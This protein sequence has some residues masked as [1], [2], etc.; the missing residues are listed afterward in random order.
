M[1]NILQPQSF[2][3]SWFSVPSNP[4]NPSNGP[5]GRPR[6]PKSCS[7]PCGTW[8]LQRHSLRC[9]A[10]N[11]AMRKATDPTGFFFNRTPSVLQDLRYL[12][13][14]SSSGFVTECFKWCF[15][16][17]FDC[18]LML[19]GDSGGDA[20]QP[21]CEASSHVCSVRLVNGYEWTTSIPSGCPKIEDPFQSPQD[22]T[23][24]RGAAP[25]LRQKE[26]SWKR[27]QRMEIRP[28]DIEIQLNPGPLKVLDIRRNKKNKLRHVFNAPCQIVVTVW[29][30]CCGKMWTLNWE[31]R[32]HQISYLHHSSLYICMALILACRPWPHGW[33]LT[34]LEMSILDSWKPRRQSWK[35]SFEKKKKPLCQRTIPGWCPIASYIGL[36]N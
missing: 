8:K 18:Y 31:A 6:P 16:I 7:P 32:S 19:S 9:E 15:D 2:D 35:R 11:E 28:P 22:L 26:T 10:Q 5:M 4:S 23:W 1:Y 34:R 24:R 3:V 17:C 20:K 27:M 14:W 29:L 13:G 36:Y 33:F 25:L 30:D 12:S 21:L